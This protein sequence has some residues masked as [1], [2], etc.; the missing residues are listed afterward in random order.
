MSH[1][2]AA[3]FVLLFIRN[4]H[5]FG[6]LIWYGSCLIA[7]AGIK[8][9]AGSKSSANTGSDLTLVYLL[10]ITFIILMVP[11]LDRGVIRK[12]RTLEYKLLSLLL[13]L[14]CCAVIFLSSAG[15]ERISMF[16]LMIAYQFL[17]YYLKIGL[18]RKL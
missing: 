13:I 2:A 8:F 18:S 5:V 4:R 7:L 17:F 12:L 15:A 3:I 10:L 6:K 9:G 11:L 16:C 1:N 14:S